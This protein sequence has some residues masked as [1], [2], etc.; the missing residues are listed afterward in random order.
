MAKNCSA[1]SELQEKSADFVQNGVTKSV[2]NALKNNKGFNTSSGNDDCTDLNN[3]NDCLIGNMEDEVDAYEVCDWKEFTKNFIHNL[4]TVLGAIICAICGLWTKV[5]KHDCEIENLYEGAELEIGEES[6]DGSYVRP[7]GGVTYLY[8]RQSSAGRTSDVRLIYIAGGLA[9]VQGSF[10]F[11]EDD[12][13]DKDGTQRSGNH[14]WGV[15]GSCVGGGEL[16]CEIR[17]KK[18]QF[19]VKNIYAGLGQETGGGGYHVNATVFSAGSY[20]YGQ[21]GGCNTETGVA[22]EGHSAGHLVPDGYI[23]VQ[24]RMSYIWELNASGA[25]DPANATTYSPRAWMGIRFNRSGVKC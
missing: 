21:H 4:W 17:V 5:E 25:S 11:F 14:N 7:G 24:L 9:R 6:S 20:A 18:S 13:R 12:F 16:I 15:T 3:A 8:D 10:K 23:Y 1:C 22:P 2:C 19:N